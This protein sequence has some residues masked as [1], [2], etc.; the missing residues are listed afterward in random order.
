M[1][2]TVDNKEKR[3]RNFFKNLPK[4]TN[5]HIHL[6]ALLPYTVL[7]KTIYD[8]DRELYNKIYGLKEDFIVTIDENKSATI[9][10]HT[11]ILINEN[12]KGPKNRESTNISDWERLANL[13]ISELMPSEITETTVNPFNEFERIQSRY[14]FFI[15]HYK[16]YYYLL[17]TSL[18]VN[19][20]NNVFYLNLRGK[21]GSINVDVNFS[22]KLY[23]TPKY[24]IKYFKFQEKMKKL[25]RD[26]NVINESHISFMHNF[27][28][29]MK[30]DSDII[31]LALYNFNISKQYSEF[32]DDNSITDVDMREISKKLIEMFGDKKNKKLM[33]MQYIITFGKH[34]K[35]LDF[36]LNNFEIAIKIVLYCAIIINR[37]YG[38]TFFNGIDLVGNEQDSHGL[39]KY[40]PLLRSIKKFERYNI[41]IIPHFGETNN[42]ENKISVID[43]YIFDNKIK[44]I[45][46]AISLVSNK[47][48]YKYINDNNIKIYVE[49]CPISNYLLGYYKPENHPHKKIVNNKNLRLVICSDDNAIFGYNT[50]SRDYEYIWKYWHINIDDLKRIILNGINCIG[51]I[52]QEYYYEMFIEM[53]QYVDKDFLD[54]L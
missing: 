4:I 39:D 36:D 45:G 14:R 13:K 33:M 48:V 49:S 40:I 50:V 32:I 42:V 5:N 21:P 22:E 54:S 11:L 25:I 19:Y 9:L 30:C 51:I 7:L 31:I 2:N 44:R 15:R 52:F 29:R 24:H 8:I 26:D 20:N 23:L 10:K 53:W 3:V 37:E 18:F 34:P 28:L 6:F 43:K 16:V 27:Y 47:K 41:S 17:Y 1:K 35:Y 12:K 38:F 46:H